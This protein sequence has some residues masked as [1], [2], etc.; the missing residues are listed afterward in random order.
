MP[1]DQKALTLEIAGLFNQAVTPLLERMA[2]LESRLSPLADVRDRLVVVETK[3]Q[4]SADLHGRILAVET[5]S[6]APLDANELAALRAAVDS[7]RDL[8]KDL[9]ALRER[10]AVAEVR[11][12]VPG[13]PGKD[14]TNGRDGLDGLGFDEVVAI[15][16][17]DARTIHLQGEK[18]GRVKTLGT[19]VL[20]YEQYQGVWEDGRGYVKGDLVTWAG[21]MWHCS[22]PTV[23]KPG[24]GKAWTLAVKRG[25][26]GRDGKDAPQA[27]PVIRP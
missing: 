19:F 1:L 25:R 12:P 20:P 24:D 23:V 11:Q 9:A 16:D 26:D 8:P 15:Q 10:V 18:A 22:D 2:A 5:K 7:L 27:L 6:A 4:Q 17:A 13:P 3:M 14:G 21:S